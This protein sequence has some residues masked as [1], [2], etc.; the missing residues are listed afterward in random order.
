MFPKDRVYASRY[1]HCVEINSDPEGSKG[2]QIRVDWGPAESDLSG[3]GFT[4]VG[5]LDVIVRYRC[6]SFP[7][8]GSFYLLLYADPYQCTLHE[9]FSSLF[10]LFIFLDLVCDCSNPTE[11]RSS[12]RFG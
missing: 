9:V 1:I 3:Q 5:S 4:G 2:G 6:S 8:V 11:T 10:D 7:T 12:L